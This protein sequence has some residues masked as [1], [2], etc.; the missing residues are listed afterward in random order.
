MTKH[1]H[2]SKVCKEYL[3]DNNIL[4]KYVYKSKLLLNQIIVISL[5]R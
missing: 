1:L 3:I 5:F 2:F 4:K